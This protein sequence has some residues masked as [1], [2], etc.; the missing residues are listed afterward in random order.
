MTVSQI[1]GS[2][3][4]VVDGKI[5]E[6]STEV[7][8]DHVEEVLTK[9]LTREVEIADKVFASQELKGKVD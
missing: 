7:E 8:I 3:K 2:T 5:V 9:T 1:S 6:V 4:I